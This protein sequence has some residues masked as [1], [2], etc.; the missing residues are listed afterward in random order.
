MPLA[1][2]HLTTDVDDSNLTIYTTGSFTTTAGRALLIG[3]DIS[4]TN[5][6]GQPVCAKTGCTF[7]PLGSIEYDAAGT[8]YSI[9]LLSADVAST[10]TGTMTITATEAVSGCGWTV[11]EVTG[12]DTSDLI[13]G[14]AV[15]AS[16][17]S[18]TPAVNL[19]A[20]ASASNAAFA[21]IGVN[22]DGSITAG[23]NFTVLG[24][25]QSVAA[26]PAR[27]IGSEWAPNDNT[28]TAT[29]PSG[30]WGIVAVEVRAEP[31]AAAAVFTRRTY[32]K[33]EIP[34]TTVGLATKGGGSVLAM[35]S[36]SSLTYGRR[37]DEMSDCAVTIAGGDCSGALAEV[38][39]DVNPWEHELIVWRGTEEVWVGTVQGVTWTT[40]D[41]T[42]RGRDIFQWLE[43]RIMGRNGSASTNQDLADT[44]AGMGADGIG[45][46]VPGPANNDPLMEFRFSATG[47]TAF[48]FVAQSDM[49]YAADGMRSLAATVVDWTVLR[50]VVWAGSEEFVADIA[51]SAGHTWKHADGTVTFGAVL[52]GENLP[53]SPTAPLITEHVDDQ[54]IDRIP[55][56][57]YVVIKGAYAGQESDE[58]FGALGSQPEGSAGGINDPVLGTVDLIETN[59][60]VRDDTAAAAAAVAR[61]ALFGGDQLSCRWLPDSSVR[62]HHLVPGARVPVAVQVGCRLLDQDMRL[63]EVAVRVE[64]DNEAVMLRLGPVS[65]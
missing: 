51:S 41:V 46:D 56:V 3:V 9:F 47:T 22:A 5:P 31:V 28:V 54:R 38:L 26:A 42:I 62:F 63:L 19:P 60:F 61:K 59:S 34:E 4:D 27:C 32:G 40:E 14:I 18:T 57:S 17:T 10:S 65:S 13:E 36:Y 33:P 55:E 49:R 23:L 35:L 2:T 44:F 12:H 29:G 16:G 58:A 24:T 37:L 11:S 25:D 8:R 50:R 30:Q 52:S 43:H 1:F 48:I 39:E 6:A 21:V 53:V 7:T 45:S 15:T 20:F 64:A